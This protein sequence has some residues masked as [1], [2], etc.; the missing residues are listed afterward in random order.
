M[1][2]VRVWFLFVSY[3]PSMA[4]VYWLRLAPALPFMASRSALKKLCFLSA[5]PT[6]PHPSIRAADMHPVEA[7]RHE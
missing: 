2:D 5:A 1:N 3:S 7:L 6:G 4:R